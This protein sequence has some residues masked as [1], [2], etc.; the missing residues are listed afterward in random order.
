MM[1]PSHAFHRGGRDP[2]GRRKGTA[3]SIGT[4][5]TTIPVINADLDGVVRRRPAV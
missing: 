3:E 4:R 2:R 5:T 1:A